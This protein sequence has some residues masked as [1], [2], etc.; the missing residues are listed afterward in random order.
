MLSLAATGLAAGALGGCAPGPGAAAT[1]GRSAG[2]GEAQRIR[3]AIALPDFPDRDFDVT[4]YGARGDGSSD[5]SAAIAAAI[6]ACHQAGGGRVLVPAGVFVSGPIHLRS[7]VN[8]HLRKGAE[9]SF[10]TDPDRY[11]PP[12][13]TRWEGMELMSYSPLVY[14]RG[15]ENI[16]VTGE[17]VLNGNADDRTWWPWKGPHSEQHWEVYPGQDQAPA[18]R[19]LEQ[20]AEAGVPVAERVHGAGSWLRP[21]LLQV[22]DC[23]RVLIEGV[24][25]RDSPFWLI[26]PVLCQDVTVRG[27]TCSSH[28][29]NSDGCNPESC[30]RV[31]IEHC[32]FDTGDDCIAIKSGRNADG[33]RLATPS[34]NIVI[35]DCRMRAGHGG[36]VIG[37]EISGGVHNVYAERCHMSS[38]ELERAL[39]IKTN[40]MRGGVIEHIRYRDITVGE[41]KDVLVINFFYEEGDAGAFDPIVRDVEI[42]D[43]T[44]EKAGRVFQVRGFEREPVQDLR[45]I[46]LSVAQAD[47]IGVI[48]HVRGL[49]VESVSINGAPYRP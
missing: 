48:E 35:A 41:V 9:I 23:R 5:S 8:L 26:H 47:R 3:A 2:W 19:Q 11:L 39:R 20:Q 12:V 22:Y 33:R 10:V 17:G 40:S 1:A 29:P 4:A 30:D 31:L 42:R 44:V 37:S 25:L 46:N 27:V 18:R 32:D 13:F 16:A 36:V 15:E 7:N 21:P 24:T 28:G 49:S 38:P 14:A 43:V 45:L 34:R 6:A